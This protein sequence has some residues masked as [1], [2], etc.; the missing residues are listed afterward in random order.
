MNIFFKRSGKSKEFPLLYPGP[1]GGGE[2]KPLLKFSEF[3]E[4]RL[5]RVYKPLSL[6][7]AAMNH[8]AKAYFFLS[9]MSRKSL[10]H[11]KISQRGERGNFK[12]FSILQ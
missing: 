1:P 9:L 3:F 5:A 6:M 12:K 2:H 7:I 8:L 10:W 11:L 4:K